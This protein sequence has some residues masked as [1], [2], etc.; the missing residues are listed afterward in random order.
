M[1]KTQDVEKKSK[2]A[3]GK[4]N[5]MLMIAGIVTILLGFVIMTLDNETFGFGF[6][7]LTLGPII[8]TAGFVIEFFA[9]M[10]KDKNH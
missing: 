5:Y 8:L 1:L 3:F 2:L 7:G 10:I 4:K 6:L 9:I